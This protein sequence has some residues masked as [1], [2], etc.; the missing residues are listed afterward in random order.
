MP[1]FAAADTLAAAGQ[2]RPGGPDRLDRGPDRLGG[3]DSDGDDNINIHG[4]IY[5]NDII[6]GNDD[7]DGNDFDGND[8]TDRNDNVSGN[9]D[10]DGIHHRDRNPDIGGNH[11]SRKMRLS[12]IVS[13]GPRN[14]KKGP[15]P[16]STSPTRVS[17][18]RGTS[19]T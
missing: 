7:I 5:E 16:C 12:R 9:H 19:G 1:P 10:I 4:N 13:G 8:D 15:E 18:G 3:P 2:N 11:L 6:D 17:E 14:R